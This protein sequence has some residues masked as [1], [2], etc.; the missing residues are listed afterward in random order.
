MM[1][2]VEM[3]FEISGPLLYVL[4]ESRLREIE[5]VCPTSFQKE[6]SSSL[7]MEAKKKKKSYLC[8][9]H[10]LSSLRFIRVIT[11]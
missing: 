1:V 11:S 4:E 2:K 3:T 6:S 5:I 9:M 10:L 8:I 7:S